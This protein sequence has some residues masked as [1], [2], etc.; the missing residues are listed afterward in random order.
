MAQKKGTNPPAPAGKRPTPPP[1]PPSKSAKVEERAK[2]AKGLK[3]VAEMTDQELIDAYGMAKLKEA[4]N[5]K[6]ANVLK[7]VLKARTGGKEGDFEG[8]MF[9]LAARSKARHA[10]S[11]ELV[12]KKL[13]PEDLEECYADTEYME[14]RAVPTDKAKAALMAEEENEQD[15]E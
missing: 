4:L 6:T 15:N 1:N 10:L 7:E 14:Y 11:K 13:S 3:T 12:A 9:N 2:G 5:K 8:T